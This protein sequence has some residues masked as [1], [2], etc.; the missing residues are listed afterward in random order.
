MTIEIL[1]AMVV[2]FLA[3]FMTMSSVRHLTQ[4]Y[5]QKQRY[6]HLYI[7]VLSL[8]EML[9]AQGCDPLANQ[10]DQLNGFDYTVECQE[11][12]MLKNY[13]HDAEG[14]RSGNIGSFNLHLYDIALE[15]RRGSFYKHY[16]FTQ[17][18]EEATRNESD[19]IG[20]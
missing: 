2:G 6:E 8:K 15:L 20:F 1:V 4:T 13:E 14:I 18:Q 7:T 9:K 5:L 11:R 12:V 3:I 10:S 17:T 16:H 19:I